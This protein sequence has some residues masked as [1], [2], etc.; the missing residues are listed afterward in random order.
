MADKNLFLIDATAFCYRAYYALSGMSTVSGQPTNAVYGFLNILNKILKEQK[1]DYLVCCFDI[2]RD[3]FRLQKFAQYK[4]QRPPMP[5]GLSSQIPIIKEIVA[6]YGISIFEKK[7]FEADDIIAELARKAAAKK[8]RVT[9]VSSDKDILQLVNSR[10]SVFNPYKDSGVLYDEKKVA[11]VFGVSPE[12]TADVIA[13]MG[14]DADNIPGVPGIG[15]KTAEKLIL[16]F[17]S[18]EKLL[19]NIAKVNPEKIKNAISENIERIKLNKELITLN[20]KVGI[21][22][23]LKKVK[24]DNPDYKRLSGIFKRLEF[25]SLLKELPD[26]GEDAFEVKLDNLNSGELKGLLKG[27][28]ELALYGDNKEGLFFSIGDKIF[29]A[30]SAAGELDALISDNRIKKTGFDLKKLK[31]ALFKQGL[32][33]NGL[34][35][36]VMIAAYLLN[37][38]RSS[39]A[40]IDLAL[41]NLGEFFREEK[42]EEKNALSLVVKLKPVLKKA[43]EEKGL[44]GLFTDLEMPLVSVLAEMEQ[45]GIKLDLQLLKELSR[46]IE[47]KLIKLIADIYE[48]SGTQFNINSPKQL[49]QVLFEKLSLPVIKKTKTGP[50]TDEEVLRRLSQK[51]ALPALLLEY[52]QLTKLKN[53]YVDALPKLVSPE[54]GRVHTS[55]NQT[56]TETGRLSSSNPNLQ[57]IPI[58]TDI[59]SRIRQAIIASGKDNCLLS[60]D[61][62]Q[63]ELRVLAHLC[64]DKTLVEAFH[65][66]QDIHRLTASLIYNISESEVVDNMREVAKRVNFGIVYGQSSYGLSKDLGISVMQAQDFIDAYFLRYPKVREF[67]DAQIHKARSEGFVTT[68]MGRR[69]YIPEINSKNMGIRQ[70]AE[71]QAV[72]TPIQGTASDLIKMAMVKIAEQ[73]KKS[74]LKSKMILQIHDELVFDLPIEELDVLSRMVKEEMEQVKKLDVPIKIDMKKGKNWLDMLAY[75][76]GREAV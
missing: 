8:L 40:L 71:R 9:I 44:F 65:S 67:I 10:V 62:S 72:N 6:A 55:F 27:S 58:K 29:N 34:D 3:T 35:F 23:N 28:P 47:K 1:P 50:S 63:I 21:V 7:G 32:V 49:G 53:T 64:G 11:E 57:N 5:D 41:E 73:I 45:E 61:Y 13:L 76:A 69:R 25:K 46:D 16:E 43:L 12:M 18:L 19:K 60:C 15:E 31:V 22:L 20:E 48:S 24:F 42:L 14:D 33:L 4:M 75:P 54:T 74:G 38:S 59:G 2:S 39:Y 56:G 51:H 52:R 66:N 70:F 37:P 26:T 36:D 68:L 17:G 30:E